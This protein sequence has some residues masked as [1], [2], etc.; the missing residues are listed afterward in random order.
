MEILFETVEL[1]TVEL[2]KTTEIGRVIYLPNIANLG[3]EMPRQT[4]GCPVISQRQVGDLQHNKTEATEE[5]FFKNRSG[6]IVSPSRMS[7]DAN[8]K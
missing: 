1:E 2:E 6:L 8:D 5:N 4:V 7:V 3:Q